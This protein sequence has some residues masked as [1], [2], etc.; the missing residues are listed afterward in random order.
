M[1]E[2]ITFWAI[3]FK[4]IQELKNQAN[5]ASL[6]NTSAIVLEPSKQTDHNII[7]YNQVKMEELSFFFW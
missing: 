5:E 2:L 1:I 6:Q 3:V 7:Y 4:T